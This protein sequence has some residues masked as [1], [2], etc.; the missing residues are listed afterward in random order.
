MSFER[1]YFRLRPVLVRQMEP[2]LLGTN[3][4]TSGSN[5]GS[6][7][8]GVRVSRSRHWCAWLA[9]AVP[10][11][12]TV[13]GSDAPEAR[14]QDGS[15]QD[16]GPLTPSEV[17]KALDFKRK[18]LEETE[19]KAETLRGSVAD[20]DAER[21]RLNERLVETAALIQKSEAQMTAIEGRMSELEAQEKLVRG[22]LSQRHGQIATLLGALQRMGR[23]PPPVLITQREDAL[24]MVRSAMLLSAA[25]P[26][27]RNQ[28]VTLAGRLE[29][30]IRVMSEIRKEG[31]RLKAETERL[32][33]AR[34]RLASLMEA[35]KMTIADRQ[36]ELKAVR[37][38]SAE[39]S[40][41]VSDLSELIS[42]L[43]KTVSEKTGLGAY[44]E[45]RKAQPV[46]VT[47]PP[48]AN[49]E[50][51]AGFQVAGG[52]PAGGS[53]ADVAAAAGAG[54]P[55]G[56]P[57]GASSEGP[58]ND[59][60]TAG[61]TVNK[62]TDVALLVPERPKVQAIELTPSKTALMSANPGRIKPAI[63]FATARAK[64]PLPAHGRRV[65]SF[66]EK[67]Q[68]GGQSKGMV[69]ETRNFAQVVSPC[70]GWVVYA[71]EFRSYGQLL[72][73][74]AGDGYHVL[75]AGMSHIDVEPGQFVLTAEPV[76]TMSSGSKTPTQPA[77]SG[78]PVL[79]VEF[80]KDGRPIDPD[81]WWI[82]SQ[83]KVQG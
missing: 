42:R 76:G 14:A 57:S 6:N 75:L 13:P 63:P 16:N 5:P 44:E 45:E 82:A 61:E 78:S 2:S 66:N 50:N 20:L 10:V 28:A 59:G 67:T 53:T 48:A 37:V 74:N 69:L 79:Y 36:S 24:K 12:I 46:V 68:Y 30:L 4:Y 33:E 8:Q 26:D 72:I 52:T 81:P 80:R 60:S 27:L 15:P 54:N 62:E 39:L 64:L 47:P 65:L 77:A 21:E 73:I 32:N 7:R 58:R 40:K 18:A 9:L 1:R 3:R 17:E 83:Q 23:N 38:A 51:T 41:N 55:S 25:F 49:A 70:D 31:E 29:D 11:A 35:K 22:S 43:D 34:T 19:S 56:T 71:G